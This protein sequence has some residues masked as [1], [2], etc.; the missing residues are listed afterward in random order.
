MTINQQTAICNLVSSFGFT[1]RQARFLYLAGIG[2][3]LFTA[4]QYGQFTGTKPGA[5]QEGFI[6]KLTDHDLV[7]CGKQRRVPV[8]RLTTRKFYEVILTPDSL[9]RKEMSADRVEQ[10]LQY[11]DYLAAHPELEY[12]GTEVDKTQFFATEFGDTKVQIPTSNRTSKSLA[13]ARLFPDPF[14]IFAIRNDSGVAA[15]IVWGEPPDS[16]PTALRT[17][18]K[19]N[20]DFLSTIPR[21]HFV[22]ISPHSR[23]REA[24]EKTIR[25]LLPDSQSALPPDLERYFFLRGKIEKGESKDF[26]KDDYAC[27]TRAR[28]TYVGEHYDSLYT[29]YRKSPHLAASLFNTQSR[30]LTVELFAPTNPFSK[31]REGE[32]RLRMS[33]QVDR[34]PLLPVQS[35]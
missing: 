23:C 19:R 13:G 33:F 10:R 6:R 27:W 2:A 1:D 15:G 7:L 9:L 34:S 25:Q 35:V 20:L 4:A 16:K 29:D 26:I 14:P 3:G 8:F 31:R 30:A 5:A 12:L 18:L 28:K 21:L 22:Y 32:R 17:F 11:M 24:A